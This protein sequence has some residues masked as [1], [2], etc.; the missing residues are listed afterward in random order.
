MQSGVTTSKSALHAARVFP[1]EVKLKFLPNPPTTALKQHESY[2]PQ[3]QPH[4]TAD[5][6][7][8]K[9][10]ALVTGAGRPA[11]LGMF[12]A[13]RLA[14]NGYNVALHARQ[15]F[16]AAR[17]AARSLGPQHTAHQADLA[18]DQQARDLIREVLEAHGRLDVLIHCVG[19]Y[20]PVASL[21]LSQEQ[22]E[23]GLSS[24]ITA[25]YFTTRAALEPLRAARG[26]IILLGD[27]A[28]GKLTARQQALSYHIGKTGL[29]LL[30]HTLAR[31]EA[32][33]GVTINMISPG[34]LENSIDLET[35]PPI[36]AGRFGNF[37]DIWHVMKPLLE[38]QCEYCTGSHILVSGG[39]N[40]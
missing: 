17:E 3:Q 23:M 13:R 37:D 1:R 27:S 20:T 5:N 7:S 28:A 26:R 33:Y 39:W 21:K 24:T 6:T 11:G 36:P 10:I 40:L 2:T 19:T 32:R 34:I 8:S 30:M 15:N 9:K 16:S 22:W 31:S 38:P 25:A 35:A 14:E 18:L 12:L 4:M 29:L